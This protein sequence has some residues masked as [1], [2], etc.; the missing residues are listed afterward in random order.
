MEMLKAGPP[1]TW[2]FACANPV[3]ER[4]GISSF[5]LRL[6]GV[7]RQ[8]D[9]DELKI[10]QP[11]V[12]AQLLHQFLMTSHIRYGAIF[13]YGDAVGATHGR[14]PMGDHDDGAAGHEV[15]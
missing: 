11:A 5:L 9:V 1:L 7:P 12:G 15:L 4:M 8:F 3:M 10:I 2:P 13:N 14:E 6:R